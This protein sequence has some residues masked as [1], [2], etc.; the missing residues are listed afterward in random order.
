[1]M[2]YRKLGQSSLEVSLI[3]YGAWALSRK[4]WGDVNE[5][6]ALETVE[7]SIEN[8]INFFDTAPVYGFGKSEELLGIILSS[9]RK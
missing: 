3:G 1:M 2:E 5:K 9:V 4:G 6:E 7:K 8:G